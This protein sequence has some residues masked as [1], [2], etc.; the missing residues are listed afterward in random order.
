MKDKVIIYD[1]NCP[2][3]CAYT[4]IF[5]KTGLLKK[6]G[7]IPFSE[8]DKSDYANQL[9]LY[10][11]R[12]E[13]PLVDVNQEA[14]LYGLESMLV[15]LEQKIPFWVKVAR[16]KPFYFCLQQLY[17]LVSYN[18]TIIAAQIPNAIG[19]DCSPDFNW[20]YRFMYLTMAFGFSGF[21]FSH[22]PINISVETILLMLAF[23]IA[24]IFT[25][26]KNLWNWLGH[27]STALLMGAIYFSFSLLI[28]NNMFFIILFGGFALISYQ[29]IHRIRL[30]AY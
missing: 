26:R 8:I 13:I 7:R 18:R 16:F 14:T 29:L 20:F 9:D 25:F 24:S 6:D 17:K 12:H 2:M 10:R 19:F 11:S 23:F 27:F 22:L 15:I 1:D 3:C 28:P 5:I 30:L 21:I 4:N